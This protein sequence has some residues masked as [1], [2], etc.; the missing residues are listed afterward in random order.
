MQFQIERERG[1][2]YY[3]GKRGWKWFDLPCSS[4][5]FGIFTLLI[6]IAG[7]V[8]NSSLVMSGCDNEIMFV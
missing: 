2:C 8:Q 7:G 3:V 4:V 5:S 1:F 6:L